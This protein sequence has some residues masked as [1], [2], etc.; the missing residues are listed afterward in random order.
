MRRCRRFL[1]PHNLLRCMVHFPN[2][3]DPSLFNFQGSVS[4]FIHH[5]RVSLFSCSSLLVGIAKSLESRRP[6]RCRPWLD[7][8]RGLSCYLIRCSPQLLDP[9]ALC[10]KVVCPPFLLIVHQLS[11]DLCRPYSLDIHLRSSLQ[12]PFEFLHNLARYILERSH[13]FKN[14]TQLD[15]TD[16]KV[17]RSGAT[18]AHMNLLRQIL[19]VSTQKASK[20]STCLALSDKSGANEAQHGP[21]HLHHGHLQAQLPLLTGLGDLL[22]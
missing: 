9:V 18:R 22:G 12:I 17:G 15:P 2:R 11:S 7:D 4:G 1:K 8:F 21:S 16:R 6:E 14:F 5:S 3:S 19:R 13:L 20:L 10:L